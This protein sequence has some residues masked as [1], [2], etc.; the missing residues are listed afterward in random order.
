MSEAEI[1]EILNLYVSNALTSYTIFISFLFAYI[2]AVY[3]A[4]DALSKPQAILV[5]S[6]YFIAA[7]APALACIA[8]CNSVDNLISKHPEIAGS[9]LWFLPWTVMLSIATSLTMIGSLYFIYDIRRKA[10]I[11]NGKET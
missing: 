8:M 7:A 10:Q 5:S 4:G 2:V 11:N 9:W 3:V 6:L 1:L